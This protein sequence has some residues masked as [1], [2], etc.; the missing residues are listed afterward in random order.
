[1]DLNFKSNQLS[2]LFPHHLKIAQLKKIKVKIKTAHYK[3][4]GN[5]ESKTYEKKTTITHPAILK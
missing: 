1:M 4:L 2:F 5:T 3:N